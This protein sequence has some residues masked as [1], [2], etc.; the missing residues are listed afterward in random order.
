[1]VFYTKKG[2]NY[3]GVF[4][5]IPEFK[6]VLDG[7]PK[8]SICSFG[9]RGEASEGYSKSLIISSLNFMFN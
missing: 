3:F 9:S 4:K 6:E 2:C 1:M 7:F 5:I 8:A